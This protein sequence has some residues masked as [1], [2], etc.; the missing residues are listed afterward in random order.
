[1]NNNNVM[2]VVLDRY[3]YTISCTP[4]QLTYSD[5]LSLY[6]LSQDSSLNYAQGNYGWAVMDRDG[7]WFYHEYCDYFSFDLSN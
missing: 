4:Y 1:M 2:F 7:D 6:N 5:L 3:G